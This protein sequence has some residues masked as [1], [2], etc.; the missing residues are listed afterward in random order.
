MQQIQ[1]E[2]ICVHIE[3]ETSLKKVSCQTKHLLSPNTE[4]PP[5]ICFCFEDC[6]HLKHPDTD[7]IDYVGKETYL[8]QI[9]RFLHAVKLSI[10]SL[11]LQ[12]AADPCKFDACLCFGRP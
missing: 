5:P 8:K 12:Y 2:L 4:H 7:K 11:C 9:C 10:W 3:A 1:V 6:I